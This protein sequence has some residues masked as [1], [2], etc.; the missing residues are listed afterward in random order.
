[1]RDERHARLAV[2]AEIRAYRE[3]APSGALL[4][5]LSRELALIGGDCDASLAAEVEA[6]RSDAAY[7]L[8]AVEAVEERVRAEDA[9]EQAEAEAEAVAL[10]LAVHRAL[11]ETAEVLQSSCDKA[12]ALRNS[13]E[14]DD[15]RNTLS[16]LA[17]SAAAA[18]RRMDGLVGRLRLLERQG[19]ELQS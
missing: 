19:K 15:V 10:T 16:A 6:A 7:S 14:L 8:A 9:T 4:A 11:A 13:E 3:L 5:E 18:A 2:E 1:M 17:V 12:A